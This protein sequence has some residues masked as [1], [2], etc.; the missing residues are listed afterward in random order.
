MRS[1]PLFALATLTP[2]WASFIP[3]AGEI[4]QEANELLSATKTSAS[5]TDGLLTV[6]DIVKDGKKVKD[7]TLK[8]TGG[9][10]TDNFLHAVEVCGKHGSINLTD[11]E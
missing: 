9:D 10:D 8:S 7:C 3:S 4:F 6:S 5:K 2:V 11:P 1:T